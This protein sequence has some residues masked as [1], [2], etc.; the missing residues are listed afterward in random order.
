MV[1]MCVGRQRRESR[2]KLTLVGGC[3]KLEWWRVCMEI[4]MDQWTCS[5]EYR[6]IITSTDAWNPLVCGWDQPP[7]QGIF[8]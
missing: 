4:C 3:Y 5:V 1:Y 6:L 7:L 2:D 8:R